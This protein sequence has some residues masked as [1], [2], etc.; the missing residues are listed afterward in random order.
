MLRALVPFAE[1]RRGEGILQFTASLF[2][3]EV[4]SLTADSDCTFDTSVMISKVGLHGRSRTP[5]QNLIS[6]MHVHT[7]A[8]K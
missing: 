7:H 6:M 1:G 8:G 3:N 4:H 5:S 2:K